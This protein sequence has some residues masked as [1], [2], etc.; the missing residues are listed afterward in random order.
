MDVSRPTQW[1]IAVGNLN[2]DI[3]L[4]LSR[5]PSKDDVVF[6]SDSWIGVGG[7]A[8]NYAIAVARMGHRV[9]L[10]ARTGREAVNLGILDKLRESG[11]DVEWV[12]IVDGEPMGVVVVLMVPGESVRTMITIRGANAGLRGEMIP[13][14]AGDHLHL[15]SVRYWIVEEVAGRVEGRSI[16]YDP[17]GEAI[18]DPKEVRRVSSLV[19][20]VFLNSRELEALTGGSSIDDA[21]SMIKGNLKMVLVKQGMGGA[22]LVTRNESIVV[23]PPRGIRVVDVTGAGDAFDAAF[24]IWFNASAP[25]EEALRAAVAAGAAKVCRR[26]SSNMPTLGEVYNYLEL[27]PMPRKL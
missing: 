2:L 7:A 20:I 27:V 6:A 17:G 10:V 26:G 15:S 22:F 25:L 18:R 23:D 24:N 11:V 14:K 8:T 9:S 19:D 12:E 4:S 5:F 16:S 21:R 13:F 3:S 1:H